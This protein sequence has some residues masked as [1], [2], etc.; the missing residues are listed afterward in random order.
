MYEVPRQPVLCTEFWNCIQDA[1]FEFR[2]SF[3]PSWD[4]LWK[5]ADPPGKFRVASHLGHRRFLT[6]SFRSILYA[7]SY[8]SWSIGVV[9]LRLLNEE[10]VLLKLF[11]P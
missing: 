9:M 5:R 8:Y 7:T 11:A 10:S 2:P 3:R 6:N 4:I 1:C